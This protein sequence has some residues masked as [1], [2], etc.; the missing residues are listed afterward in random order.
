M[1]RVNTQRWEI[2]GFQKARSSR[3]LENG[4]YTPSIQVEIE[5]ISSPLAFASIALETCANFNVHPPKRS[6]PR[7]NC[8]KVSRYALTPFSSSNIIFLALIPSTIPAFFTLLSYILLPLG[9]TVDRGDRIEARKNDI[10][11]S[12]MLGT[13]D[14]SVDGDT[15]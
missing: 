5:E 14:R 11:F 9:D 1:S 12:R 3:F 6:T 13:T 2:R 15:L 8:W 10:F 4:R 7:S